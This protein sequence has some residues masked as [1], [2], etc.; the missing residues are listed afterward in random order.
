MA[1][2][3]KKANVFQEAND[4][5]SKWQQGAADNR[6]QVWSDHLANLPGSAGLEYVSGWVGRSESP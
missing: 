6:L 2:L 1:V 5:L 3:C 4:N